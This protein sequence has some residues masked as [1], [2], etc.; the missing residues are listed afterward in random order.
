MT[1]TVFTTIATLLPLM[2]YFFIAADGSGDGGCCASCYGDTGKCCVESSG[3]VCAGQCYRTE[4][5]SDDYYC[6]N[7]S[8]MGAGG[9]L[10]C[11]G[12]FSLIFCILGYC[13]RREYLVG[14]EE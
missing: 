2:I 14:K 7:P 9:I 13:F 6:E 3:Y 1:T 8:E 5:G 12:A 11:L 10:I 4:D